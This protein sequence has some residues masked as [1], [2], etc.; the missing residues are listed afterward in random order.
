MSDGPTTGKLSVRGLNA[1]YG[2]RQVLYD[3][4]LEI[5]NGGVTAIIGPSGCGKSTFLRCL[6]RL[7]EE[8]PGG[9][10]DGSIKL[11]DREIRDQNEVLVRC[12]IGMVFQRPSPFPNMS[13]FENVAA[14][15]R[16]LGIRRR[17]ELDA[18]VLDS[19][20]KAGLWDEVKDDVDAPATS[21]SGGQQQRLCIARALAVGPEVLLLDEPCSALDP[22]ATTKVEHLIA[23]LK[24]NYTVV[25]VTHNLAQATRVASHTAFFYLGKLV[26]FD[27]T[28]T[29]FHSAKEQLTQNYVTG[30]FG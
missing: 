1:W 15:L 12:R 7:H 26:E 29:I 8:T 25:I 13:I 5:P 30:L 11:D 10:V 19:L 18:G 3:I 6:N 4:D 20:R 23:G 14:G 28:E 17:E 16:L 2:K 21:L 22:I 27:T 24:E 9:R